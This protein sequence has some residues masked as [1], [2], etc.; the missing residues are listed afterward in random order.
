MSESESSPSPP[1]EDP[2][3]RAARV[4]AP[5]SPLERVLAI[6]RL[7]RGPE[8]CPWDREQT[9]ESMTP[10]LQE[11]TFEVV[12]AVAARDR[13][14]FTEELG[15]LLFLVLFLAAVGEDS[16]WSTLDSVADGVVE[17]L[18]RRHPHVF[19]E[20]RELGTG[21]ALQQWEEIKRAERD[22]GGKAPTALGK[23]PAGLPALTTAYRISEKAAA[24]GFQWPDIGGAMAKLEEE[25]GEFREELG[26]GARPEKLEDEI[27]DL[28]YSVVNLARY[29]R[30]DPERALR[31]TTAKFTR[32]FRYI[33]ERLHERG[34]SPE[35]AGL[36]AM[37]ALW[38][39]AKAEG[40]D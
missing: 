27:G 4:R 14:G 13:A 5:R 26:A 37:D 6:A 9:V 29:L 31:G 33:E 16:G 32:R 24:V 7:L 39:E 30:V 36:E 23:R 1:S 3:A 21:G 38:N 40:V 10:Y 8:G 18:I 2:A 22:S 17:K 12:E 19:G 35:R 28:L 11:E 15:D 34:L 25:M 20:G